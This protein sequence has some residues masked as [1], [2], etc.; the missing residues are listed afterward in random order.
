[1][2]KLGR[3]EIVAELGRGAMG[4]VFRGRDP[5]IDRTVAIKTI[6]LTA[7]IT[8]EKER[9]FL[10]RFVREAQAAGKLSHP[11]IVTVYDVG[12]GEGES[13]TP[14]IVMEYIAGRTL[15]TMSQQSPVAILEL[16]KQVAEALH[17]AHAQGIVHRDVKP[18]NIMV[19]QEGRAKIT[20]FGVAKLT[21]TEY[22]APGQV[23]G[24]PSYLSPEQLSGEKLDGRSDIFSLGVVLYFLLTGSKPFSGESVNELVFKIAYQEPRPPSELNPEL[25]ANHDYVV[26]RALAKKPEKRYQNGLAFAADL[27]DLRRGLPP[28]SRTQDA[29]AA[30]RTQ[31]APMPGTS[32]TSEATSTTTV[33]YQPGIRGMMQ[34]ISPPFRIALV[35]ALLLAIVATISF[36][37][38]PPPAPQITQGTDTT[39]T[40]ASATSGSD[41]IGSFFGAKA[42]TLRVRGTHPFYSAELS[43]WLDDKLAQTATLHRGGIRK[44][45]FGMKKT[46]L[47]GSF[48][49]T[50]PTT[51]GVHELKLQVTQS[52]GRQQTRTISGRFLPGAEKTLRISFPNG[53]LTPSWVE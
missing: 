44:Q 5:R 39:A 15:E 14:F 23:L 41:S 37:R 2:Q 13:H 17:Y 16:I 18:A 48:D 24:T 7:G 6:L 49:F 47:A 50:V 20:D 25:N 21:L 26:L 10:E 42:A 27:D 30:E 40:P 11:G 4:T 31:V 3:Y 38:P 29:P 1:M 8:K 12:E 53:E 35:L 32:A 33:I 34:R 52:D 45:F 9:E 43:L 46:Q 28:R 19:T 51:E 22:T 36:F